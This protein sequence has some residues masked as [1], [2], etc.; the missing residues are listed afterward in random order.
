MVKINHFNLKLTFSCAKGHFLD[1]FNKK[2]TRCKEAQ[3]L[4][5]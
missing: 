2:N 1:N 4:R 5:D 3:G